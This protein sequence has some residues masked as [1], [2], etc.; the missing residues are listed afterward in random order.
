LRTA[1]FPKWDKPI[2]VIWSLDSEG[3]VAGFFI[4]AVEAGK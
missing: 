4:K 1:T 3:R 2:N